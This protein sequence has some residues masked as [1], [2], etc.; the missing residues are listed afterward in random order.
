MLECVFDLLDSSPGNPE[1]S[2]VELFSSICSSRMRT[3]LHSWRATKTNTRYDYENENKIQ[4]K[5]QTFPSEKSKSCK[6]D[7]QLPRS[8]VLILGHNHDGMIFL[9]L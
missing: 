2:S 6:N 3:N 5:S 1:P 4:P 7:L 8:T 9:Q